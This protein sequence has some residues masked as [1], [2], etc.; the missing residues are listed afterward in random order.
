MITLFSNSVLIINVWLF[1]IY[2]I[3]MQ[4]SD[5]YVYFVCYNHLLYLYWIMIWWIICCIHVCLYAVR[6]W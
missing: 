1:I 3:C 5:L 6:H 4:S 2:C